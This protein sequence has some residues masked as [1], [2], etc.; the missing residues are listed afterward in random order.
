[1]PSADASAVAGP[2]ALVGGVLRG[3]SAGVLAGLAGS[4]PRDVLDDGAVP[5]LEARRWPR[6]AAAVGPVFRRIGGGSNAMCTPWWGRTPA[7]MMRPMLPRGMGGVAGSA[8]PEGRPLLFLAARHGATAAA[9][10]VGGCRLG[11]QG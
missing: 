5:T 8:G 3:S 9:G 7:A 11:Y 6:F 1:M 2:A 10:G 4:R